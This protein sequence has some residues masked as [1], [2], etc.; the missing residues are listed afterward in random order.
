MGEVRNM[1]QKE[2]LPIRANMEDL[3]ASM[4]IFTQRASHMVRMANISMMTLQ[5]DRAKTREEARLLELR[6][7]SHAAELITGLQPN[8]GNLEFAHDGQHQL[9]EAAQ[10]AFSMIDGHLR[11]LKIRGTEQA[12]SSQDHNEPMFSPQSRPHTPRMGVNLTEMAPTSDS[13]N[14]S[15][16]YIHPSF[17]SHI[18]PPPSCDIH[19]YSKRKEE[20]YSWRTAHQGCR[21]RGCARSFQDSADGHPSPEYPE[22]TCFG[23]TKCPEC[24]RIQ[25]TGRRPDCTCVQDIQDAFRMC[26]IS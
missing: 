26:G 9:G 22:C 7:G 10:Q 14:S 8:V 18:K 19:R 24:T 2:L 21:I 4:A 25:D 5:R 6:N 23:L 11:K 16:G 13:L 3:N 17:L 1:V 15:P 12:S 20:M